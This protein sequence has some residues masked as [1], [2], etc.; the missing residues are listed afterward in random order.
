M[1]MYPAELELSVL[2]GVYLFINSLCMQA[3]KALASLHI[4]ADAPES[5]LHD[6][7]I[8]DGPYDLCI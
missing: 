8:R 2:D 3:A 5:R 6:N 4:C 7:A 1:L